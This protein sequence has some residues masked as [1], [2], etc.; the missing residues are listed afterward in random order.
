[1]LPT[2]LYPEYEKLL[3]YIG[4][5]RTIWEVTGKRVLLIFQVHGS[6][7][8]FSFKSYKDL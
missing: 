1:M 5:N 4:F 6:V 3:D 8:R 7:D 2:L